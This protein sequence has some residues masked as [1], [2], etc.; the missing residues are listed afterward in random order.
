MIKIV[1][2]VVYLSYWDMIMGV[3]WLIIKPNGV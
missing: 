1:Y 2:D 3:V